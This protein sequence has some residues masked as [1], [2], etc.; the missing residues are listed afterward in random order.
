M[1]NKKLIKT[2]KELQEALEKLFNQFVEEVCNGSAPFTFFTER[3][4]D[5][6]VLGSFCSREGQRHILFECDVQ[7]PDLD[8]NLFQL[9]IELFQVDDDEIMD[10]VLKDSNSS[11]DGDRLGS[12]VIEFLRFIENETVNRFIFNEFLS[13]LHPEDYEED[14]KEDNQ[15]G[16]VKV[17]FPESHEQF[18]DGDCCESMWVVVPKII[19][20]L[21]YF[22]CLSEGIYAG[23]LDEDSVN[24]P[25]LIHGT[26][27]VFERSGNG[28]LLAIYENQLDIYKRL[29]AAELS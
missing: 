22:N 29:S 18:L 4:A 16:V 10:T 20:E 12:R 21:N 13:E 5:G 23:I 14:I 7:S 9:L 26:P 25:G 17:L 8:T 11:V 2:L 28:L 27:I 24:L 19:E 1:K 3:T 6:K 15:Y